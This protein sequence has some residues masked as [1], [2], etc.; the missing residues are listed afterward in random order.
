MESKWIGKPKGLLEELERLCQMRDYR[1][2]ESIYLLGDPSDSVY[3]VKRGRVKLS[4]ISETGR[5]LVL[6]LLGPGELFGEEALTG[7]RTRRLTAEA[8]EDSSVCIVKREAALELILASPKLALKLMELW[9]RR[10]RQIQEKLEDLLFKD[11]EARLSC[12]LLELAKEYGKKRGEAIEIAFRVTHQE[13]AD[14]VG[15][16]RESI[17]TMLNRF[18]REGIL[19]K[20]RYSIIIKDLTKLEHKTDFH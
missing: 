10:L 9:G 2:G 4:L 20:S 11:T 6:S 7:E 8:F 1:R 14:L 13:L 3:L 15:S 19:E 17:T 12:M 16:A 18:E 5:K